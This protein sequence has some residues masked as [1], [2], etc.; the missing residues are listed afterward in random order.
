MIAV[1]PEDILTLRAQML[2]FTVNHAVDDSWMHTADRSDVTMRCQV[3]FLAG[4]TAA[5]RMVTRGCSQGSMLVEF[6]HLAVELEKQSSTPPC[7]LRTSSATSAP[8]S[9][10]A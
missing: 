3:A 4:A 10:S 6:A 7:A 5:M 9:P 1:M 8:A 2:E